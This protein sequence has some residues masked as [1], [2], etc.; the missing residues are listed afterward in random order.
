MTQKKDVMC[1]VIDAMLA[2]TTSSIVIEAGSGVLGNLCSRSA[3]NRVK[4]G[5]VSMEFLIIW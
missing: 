4:A 1:H 5:K 2:F 3:K